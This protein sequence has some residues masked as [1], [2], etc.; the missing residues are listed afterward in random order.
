MPVQAFQLSYQL[1]L[2]ELIMSF[3]G[4]INAAN[5]TLLFLRFAY[6]LL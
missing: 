6:S 2:P 3:M 1:Q 5:P 4:S